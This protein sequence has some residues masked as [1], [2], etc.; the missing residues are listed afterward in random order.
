MYHDRNLVQ[1]KG[2]KFLSEWLNTLIA[3]PLMIK[4]ESAKMRS[5]RNGRWTNDKRQERCL[6]GKIVSRNFPR[7]RKITIFALVIAVIS[8]EE[9][10]EEENGAV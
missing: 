7:D 10:E 9:F 2:S 5:N 1:D 4:T 3:C 8:V 6:C